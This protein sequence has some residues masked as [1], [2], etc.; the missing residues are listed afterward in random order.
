[1]EAENIVASNP[2][3]GEIRPNGDVVEEK[4]PEDSQPEQP[5]T[6]TLV[7]VPVIEEEPV[8]TASGVVAG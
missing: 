3:L 5:T 2:N 7:P 4:T 6:D 1:M 8:D